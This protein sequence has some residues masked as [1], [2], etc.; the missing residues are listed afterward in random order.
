VW[1]NVV[2]VKYNSSGT[3][4]WAKTV[5][6]G[7][8]SSFGAVAADSSGNVY[9]AGIQWGTDTY[10]YGMGVSAQGAYSNGTYYDDQNAVL[11]KYKN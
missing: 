3:V 10:T 4:L 2:L 7:E 6:A 11:V 1:N 9:A 8:R 5:S